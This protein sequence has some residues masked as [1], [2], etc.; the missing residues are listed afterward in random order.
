MN[1][2]LKLLAKDGQSLREE[3]R[4][5][6]PADGSWIDVPGNG[7]YLAITDGLTSGGYGPTLAVLEYDPESRVPCAAP[8]GV[9]CYRRVRPGAPV[10]GARLLPPHPPPHKP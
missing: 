4:V 7:A 5:T 3:G 6:C 8:E 10:G 1:L 2:G 9:E